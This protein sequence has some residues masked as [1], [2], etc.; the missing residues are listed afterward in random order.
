MG[1]AVGVLDSCKLSK[2]LLVFCSGGGFNAGE[3]KV[4]MAVKNK[5]IVFS[6]S[7]I[8]YFSGIYN[9]TIKN[10]VLFLIVAVLL[11]SCSV[12]SLNSNALQMPTKSF[13]KII[14]TVEIFSC[15]DPN[16]KLCPVGQY[17]STGSG[18]AINL[19]RN[20][21]TV[22]TAGHVCETKYTSAVQKAVQIIQ[23]LDHL[24]NMHQSWPIL[25]SH[26]DQAGN[27]DLCLLWVPTLDV[28]KINFSTDEPKVGDE[29]AYVGAPMGIYH[30]PTV[31]IFKGIYSGLIDPSSAIITA[32]AIGGSSGAAV[33]NRRRE[34]VGVIWG[35]NPEFHH[36]S[37]MTSH[38]SFML[39]LKN[40][41]KKVIAANS[42]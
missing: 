12:A 28:K 35:A 4:K 36:V 6:F 26:N 5:I 42:Q 11:C 7:E 33:L 32:P 16:D 15:S 39:F 3:A 24:G 25:I 19:F 41:R 20:E 2:Y 40:V 29:L 37:V 8:Y 22:L 21:M 9:M 38:K 1:I 23:V 34:I 18:M 17:L 30:P 10:K 27:S 14:H 31:P 13:V